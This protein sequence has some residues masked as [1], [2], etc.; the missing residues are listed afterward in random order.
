MK[1]AVIISMVFAIALGLMV[2]AEWQRISHISN[3]IGLIN[4]PMMSVEVYSDTTGAA[5]MVTIELYVEL[6]QDSLQTSDIEEDARDIVT[7]L[8]FDNIIAKNSIPY[9]QTEL[10]AALRQRGHYVN[11]VFVNNIMS[12]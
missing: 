3:M 10:V 2:Y 9:I 7:S 8:D 4:I 6:E 11:N 5:N 1:S 12:R